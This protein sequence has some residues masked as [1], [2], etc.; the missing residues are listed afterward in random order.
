M[1]I[2]VPRKLVKSAAIFAV[3]LLSVYVFKVS[4]RSPKR[5][6]LLSG[7]DYRLISPQTYK[8]VLNQ[9]SVCDNKS[10]FLVFL[11]PVAPQQYAEREAVRKTWGAP[12]VDTLTLFFVGTPE[13]SVQR[14]DI[15]NRLERESMKHGDIIQMDF[16]DSYQNLTIKTLMIMNWL[17]MHCPQTHYAMKVDVDIFVNTFYLRD[18]LRSSS[19]RG[20]ITGSVISDG[21][22]RRDRKS[23]WQLSEELYPEDSFPPYVSG[24][25]YVFSWD[26][27]GKISWAS[28]FIK[29]IPLEDVYVGLCLRLLDVIPEYAYSLPFVRSLFEVRNLEYDRC[30][31]AGLVIVNGFSPAKLLAA[32][33]DFTQGYENC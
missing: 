15:Q 8:Y 17:D 31:F 2:D 25:G 26:L 29:M 5:P 30:R 20:F 7:E 10:L 23:K 6:V 1:K 13:E 22:P 12:G 24:A 32:W 33:Q 19:R 11:V 16:I 9:P 14:S 21:H 27:A 28:R 4:K 3:L 18:H